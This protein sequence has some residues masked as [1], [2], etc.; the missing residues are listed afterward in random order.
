VPASLGSISA[1]TL[2]TMDYPGANADDLAKTVEMVEKLDGRIIV[3]EAEPRHAPPWR[4]PR[5]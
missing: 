2:D 3:G 5:P 4:L 1:A